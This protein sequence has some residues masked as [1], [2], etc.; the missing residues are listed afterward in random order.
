MKRKA[1]LI[2]PIIIL[3]LTGGSAYYLTSQ[4]K[5]KVTREQTEQKEVDDIEKQ[6]DSAK[7]PNEADQ[8][9][10]QEEEIAE[11]KEKAESS[12]VKRSITP[13]LTRVDATS[14]GYKFGTVISDASS[15]TCTLKLTKSGLQAITRTAPIQL[16]TSYYT[17]A[18]F[19]VAGQD[20][21]SAG[22]WK[23]QVS[24]DGPS[25]QGS[26]NIIDFEVSL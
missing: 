11:A 7:T 23:A 12:G 21:P 3:A 5:N 18:G 6:E 19:T 4:S 2:A 9:K 17:C 20:F 22:N 24:I 1:L 25:I 8:R 15:G 13:T 14:Q 10:Q 26:S 16:V